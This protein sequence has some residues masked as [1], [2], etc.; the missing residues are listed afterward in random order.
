MIRC[1]HNNLVSQQSLGTTDQKYKII[2]IKSSFAK[3]IR[4][5]RKFVYFFLNY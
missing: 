2:I 3:S 1:E 4:R 5:I